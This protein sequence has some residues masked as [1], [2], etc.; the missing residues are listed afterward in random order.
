MTHSAELALGI[1]LLAYRNR[2]FPT[3][4]VLIVLICR[5]VRAASLKERMILLPSG[6]M[7]V[8]IIIT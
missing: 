7:S 8:G 3:E 5:F 6:E 1:M 4:Q 2:T